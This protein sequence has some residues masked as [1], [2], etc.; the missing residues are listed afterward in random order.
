MITDL[1]HNKLQSKRSGYITFANGGWGGGTCNS[2]IYSKINA[3]PQVC[4]SN[5]YL[6]TINTF[7]K[8]YKLVSTGWTARDRIPVGARF[9]APVQISPGAHPASCTMGIRAWD[10]YSAVHSMPWH[11]GKVVPLVNYTPHQEDV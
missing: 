2:E 4:N 10:R 3:W 9:S 8:L 5:L 1:F 11:E 7:L 6:Q